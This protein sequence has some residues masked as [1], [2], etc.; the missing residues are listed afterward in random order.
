MGSHMGKEEACS[1]F[2]KLLAT[3]RR[4]PRST[5][6]SWEGLAG[7][8]ATVDRAVFAEG[9]YGGN[10]IVGAVRCIPPFKAFANGYKQVPVGAGIGFAQKYESKDAV[11]L[12]AHTHSTSFQEINF[13]PVLYGDGAANQG[14]IF[15]AMACL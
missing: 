3:R 5:A 4:S 9:F 10:G 13:F 14:Q 12:G 11:T 15:E 7:S 2:M 8:V 6:V 1:K